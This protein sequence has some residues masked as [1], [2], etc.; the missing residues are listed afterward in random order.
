MKLA[1]SN[2]G[3]PPGDHRELLAGLAELG[4]G[5][6]EVVPAQVWDDPAKDA[7]PAAVERYRRAAEASGLRVIGLHGLLAGQPEMGLFADFHWRRRTMDYLVHLSALCR[8]LGGRTLVLEGRWR[9]GLPESAA[10][11]QCRDLLDELMPRIEPH[12][13]VLCFAPL[14]P[15][16]GDFCLSATDCRILA[17]A[18]DHPSFGHHLAIAAMSANDEM[19][20]APFAGVRGKLDHVHLDEPGFVALGASGRM[21]HADF[22]RH[23]AAISYFD[24]IS[25]VQRW[26]GA[27]DPLAQLAESIRFA[28]RTYLPIDTR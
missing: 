9:R 10:W 22:R 7:T 27:G 20:H 1:A 13:T 24:W 25:V 11:Q 2:L 8:D 21:D 16:R 5:G 17:S 6:L 14:A 18:I 28:A 15:G 23:L 19:V 26:R 4:V 12:G 3:L